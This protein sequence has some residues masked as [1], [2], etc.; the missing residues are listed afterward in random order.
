[1]QIDEIENIIV[2]VGSSDGSNRNKAT[3][4]TKTSEGLLLMFNIPGPIKTFAG[5]MKLT[6]TTKTFTIQL[7]NHHI[8]GRFSGRV[9]V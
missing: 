2:V 3:L 4:A 8:F 9:I 5:G 7:R 6:A 1:M